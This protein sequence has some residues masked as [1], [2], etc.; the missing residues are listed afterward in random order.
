VECF[1]LLK[2]TI[3][4]PLILS[5]FS[6][7]T[8]SSCSEILPMC[9]K[10]V[11][12]NRIFNM[13]TTNLLWSPYSV[14]YMALKPTSHIHRSSDS[15]NF[16]DE[17]PLKCTGTS[18]I[19]PSGVTLK[20]ALDTSNSVRDVS[21]SISERFTCSSSLDLVH[22]LR[23][24]CDAV[25]VGK[26][27]I[28]SDNCSLTVRR[29]DLKKTRRDHPVRIV[30]D[31]D[32]CLLSNVVSGENYRNFNN[33]YAVFNDGL[34]TF[35][36]HSSNLHRDDCTKLSFNKGSIRLIWIGSDKKSKIINP[37]KIIKDLQKRN[38]RHIMV[39]GGAVTAKYFLKYQVVD[40]A[41]LIN[42]PIKF[43]KALSKRITKD[44][45]YNAGLEII[46]SRMWGDDMIDY[47]VRLGASWPTEDLRAWP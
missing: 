39:E 23:R 36:Y 16:D 28:Q 27:T 19:V 26:M 14:K 32:L 6:H 40:R 37:I 46:G 35:V 7:V 17:Y 13:C 4:K 42:T 41:I 25:L 30:L 18:I 29:V 33:N 44:M 10:N 45:M 34:D 31:P 43:R 24:C 5:S 8:S 2:C 9:E 12:M 11:H 3:F 20:M 38:K 21:T 22:R 15:M 1:L 47:W